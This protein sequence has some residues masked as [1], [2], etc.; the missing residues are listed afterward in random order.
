MRIAT[1]NMENLGSRLDRPDDFQ[2]RMSILRPQMERLEADIL[3]LQEVNATREQAGAARRL[4]ALDRLLEGTDY[5]AFYRVSS[6]HPAT[7]AP[8]EHHNLVILSRW[9][10]ADSD[11]F[12]HDLVR[13]PVHVYATADPKRAGAPAITFDRP[14]L[15]GRIAPPGLPDLH[16]LNVHFKAPLAASIP[17]QKLDPLSW[18]ST[19]AWAEGFYLAGL[20]RAGQALEARLVVDRLLDADPQAHILVAGD[21]NAGEREVPVR[22]IAADLEDT[23]N[24]R[25]A[26]RMLVPL[27]HGLSESRRYTVVHRGRKVMLDHLFAS[28]PLVARFQSIEIH[29]EALGDELVGYSTIGDSPESY[30]AP[31]VARFRPAQTAPASGADTG[32]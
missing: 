24:G 14:I 6:R 30:H 29:N 27:S 11:Q 20:K 15:Y 18:K 22:I 32:P 31:V 16:V 12:H 8:A 26:D 19:G 7:G 21:F 5:D 25:L 3:C 23:G 9:P 28:R 17:G 2:Y 13:P 1:F 10:I 4:V